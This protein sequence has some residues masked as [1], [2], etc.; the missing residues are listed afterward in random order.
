MAS[1]NREICLA[2]MVEGVRNGTIAKDDKVFFHDK[3]GLPMSDIG[4][5][6]LTRVGCAKMCGS[7]AGWYDDIGPRLSVCKSAIHYF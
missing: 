3:W 7:G 6:V 2:N 4:N 1:Y 5:M